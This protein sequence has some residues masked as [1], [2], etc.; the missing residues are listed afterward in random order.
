MGRL[1]KTIKKFS[2]GHKLFGDS[3]TPIGA[4]FE[5]MRDATKAAEAQA[6][7]VANQKAIPLPDEEALERER[8]RRESGRRGGRAST[9]LTGDDRLGP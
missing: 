2:L 4:S 3:V 6:R 8:R 1:H 9:V 5:K 7:E